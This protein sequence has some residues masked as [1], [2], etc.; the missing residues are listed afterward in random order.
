MLHVE[1]RA[2]ALM[3]LMSLMIIGVHCFEYAQRQVPNIILL[4]MA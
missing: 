2:P 4:G 3:H 1:T